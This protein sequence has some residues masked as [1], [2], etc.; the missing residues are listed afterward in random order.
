MGC[1][2]R[3][4][5]GTDQLDLV[6]QVSPEVS[7]S[8]KMPPVLSLL[9]AQRVDSVVEAPRRSHHE[10]LTVGLREV[11]E[12]TRGEAEGPASPT[13]LPNPGPSLQ[14]G[15]CGPNCKAPSPLEPRPHPQTRRRHVPGH[16]LTG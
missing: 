2:S 3:W 1:D 7:I 8:S 11:P 6:A 14:G 13:L 4:S 10:G 5:P 12:R 16:S 9:R 15:S